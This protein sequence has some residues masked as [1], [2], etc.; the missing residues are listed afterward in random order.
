MVWRWEQASEGQPRWPETHQRHCEKWID[1]VA[2]MA[3]LTYLRRRRFHR[4]LL[5]A[6]PT[7]PVGLLLSLLSPQQ[8]AFEVR[9]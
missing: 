4:N 9:M 2:R 8:S 5:A 1:P 7:M 6:S 3:P